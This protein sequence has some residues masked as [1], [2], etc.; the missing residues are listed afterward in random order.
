MPGLLLEMGEPAVWRRRATGLRR[1]RV[2]GLLGLQ[3]RRLL[4][5]R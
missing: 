1:G 3:G 4:S 2:L 5:L